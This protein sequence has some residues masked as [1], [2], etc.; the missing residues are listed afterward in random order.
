MYS[1]EFSLLQR[2]LAEIV[3]KTKPRT[4]QS[5]YFVSCG[6]SLATLAPGKYIIDRLVNNIKTDMHTAK[7]FAV[8]CP[9]WVNEE[10]IVIL[11]SQSG[12]T[13]ETL[14]A[15]RVAKEK[16]AFIIAFTTNIDS[17]I[18]KIAD[19]SILYY[20]NILY[21]YPYTLTIFPCVYHLVF[22]LV[23]MLENSN[24]Y[25]EVQ[26][27]L[28]S[29]DDIFKK[30][31]ERHLPNAKEFAEVMRSKD[32]VYTIGAGIDYT[33]AYILTN[34]LF[35]ESLWIDSSPIHA[36]EFFHGAFEAFDDN[37]PVLALMGLGSTRVLE[38]RA[39]IFL[40]RK[41]KLLFSIDA[42]SFDLSPIPSWFK[43]YFAPLIT[44]FVAAKYCDEL[45]F[46]KGHP[47]SSRRYMGIEKY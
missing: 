34:C 46:I 22:S 30:A 14:E 6:G 31:M 25:P 15:G 20:D 3:S 35:M 27:A 12:S 37:T 26:S 43:P 2:Q 7:E 11:N 41:T 21:P 10:S 16:G 24:Y 32:K 28:S 23:D 13:K 45:A 18:T 29:T 8:D 47:I 4:V 5:M 42:E 17:E 40:Q 39:V 38:E 19:C 44:N 36:G 33:I 9:I 1:K